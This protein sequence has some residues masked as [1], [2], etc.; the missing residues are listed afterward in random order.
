M[1][2]SVTTTEESRLQ[3]INIQIYNLAM[4]IKVSVSKQTVHVIKLHQAV[5]NN[6]NNNNS[7]NNNEHICI[8]QNKNPQMR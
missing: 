4:K 7:N 6:N 1:K 2:T 5:N 3:K 8:V